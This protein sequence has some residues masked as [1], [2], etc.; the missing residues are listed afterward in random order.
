MQAFFKNVQ[1]SCLDNQWFKNLVEDRITRLAK[2]KV[3]KENC[4]VVQN[5]QTMVTEVNMKNKNFSGQCFKQKLFRRQ[6][7]RKD[8]PWSFINIG[9][10]VI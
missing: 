1:N 5:L 2:L 8:E 6:E 7:K 3:L 10:Q 9:R 4:L